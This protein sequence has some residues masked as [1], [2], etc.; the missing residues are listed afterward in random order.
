MAKSLK[1]LMELQSPSENLRKKVTEQRI[2]DALPE[3]RKMISF[4]RAYPDVATDMIKSPD[5]TFKFYFYQR[6]FLR[7][8]LRHNKVYG[9][10]PRAF[11]KSFLSMLG[12]KWRAILYPNCELF[13]SAGGKEQ[14]ASITIAKLEELCRLLPELS[15]EVNWE[16][17]KTKKSK[18]DV[19]Y[20]YRNGSKINILAA[21]ESSRGQRRTAGTIEE[22][23][24]MDK[25]ILN[26]V[27]IPTT[28]VDRLLPDG[29]RHPSEV[30]NKSQIWIT[31]A[32]YKNSFAFEKLI[33]ML[34]ESI[35]DPDK[36]FVMGGT[37]KIPVAEGLLSESF[38]NDLKMS[39]TFNEES[40][41]REYCSHW[42]GDTENAF[43][44]S[45]VFDKCRQLLLPETEHSGRSSK[46]A[47]YVLGIDVG[48][49]GC[50]TEVLVVKVTPQPVGPSIKSL[51][52][53]YSFSEE[54]FE[55]QAIN[56]KKL[57][58]KYKARICAIDGNGL[59]IGL[60]DYMIKSQIDPETGEE[61]PPFGVEND[62]E[63]FYKKYRTDN[64]ERDAM[65]IIKANA[66]I[67][68]E[69][70]SYVQTQLLN[71]K[72]KLLIDERD[73][74][75]RLMETKV[76]QGLSLE[77]RNERL[78]PY[79]L[80]TILREQMCNLVEENEGQNIILK[81]SS[82]TVLKDKFSAFGYALYYIKQEEER[83]KKRKS[84]S[85]KELMFFN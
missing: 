1:E 76:G 14:A 39:D 62:D 51:V 47:Y 32:G 68:T 64:M 61:L 24:L 74:K 7:A 4:F 43:F 78:K 38:V 42:S 66:P 19:E 82:K 50:S 18:D 30:I 10:F 65:F 83:R 29:T 77:Q 56:I 11:S 28:N 22:A 17:G 15:T 73:A 41:E 72:I 23:I 57:F 75:T 54:H 35:I 84:R 31:T 8:V 71:G 81:Q 6:I 52:N 25:T 26:E 48:R 49:K 53:L 60:I 21:R 69:I 34:I 85:A 2:K 59:G 9:T 80:T 67:N 27:I 5:S 13:V 55:T 46:S 36:T 20:Q 16:R 37:Y 45:E 12:Q 44:S 33:E 63:G 58:Y 79:V 40:F 70:Y 3:L